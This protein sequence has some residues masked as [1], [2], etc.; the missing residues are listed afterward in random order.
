MKKGKFLKPFI[1][2]EIISNRKLNF[3]IEDYLEYSRDGLYKMIRRR[4][5]K[6]V[7]INI[8]DIISDHL[9]LSYEEIVVKP[10]L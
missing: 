7:S 10:E 9:K 8:L 2:A 5:E 4:D 1:A 6:L 3:E